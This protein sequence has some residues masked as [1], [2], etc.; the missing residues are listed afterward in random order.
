M[1]AIV[2]WALSLIATT[3]LVDAFIRDIP[4]LMNDW[5]APALSGRVW[6]L[7]VALGW[8][9]LVHATA[10]WDRDRRGLH[11]KAAGTIVIKVRRAAM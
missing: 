2:R 4:E 1:Q 3:P 7:W 6:W 8:W 5:Q 10:L 11:D 9:L